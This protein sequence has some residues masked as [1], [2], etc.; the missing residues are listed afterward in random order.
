MFV[1]NFSKIL[2]FANNIKNKM[3]ISTKLHWI[4]LK[5]LLKKK[6]KKIRVKILKHN[7]YN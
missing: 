7:K 3:N 5:N 6:I 4:G 1:K 2:I